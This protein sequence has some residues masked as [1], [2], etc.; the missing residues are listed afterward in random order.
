M[1]DSYTPDTPLLIKTDEN[2]YINICPIYELINEGKIEKDVLG[3][4]YDASKKNYKVLCLS[5][6]R[7]PSYI[8]RHKTN[9]DI[10]KISESE[11][12]MEVDVT[13]DHSLFDSELKKVS[14]KDLSESSNLKYYTDNIF[15]DFNTF[16]LNNDSIN[17]FVKYINNGRFDRIHKAVLNADIESK[18]KILLL[19]NMDT[20]KRTKTM[21]AGIQFLQ[22]C[23][24]NS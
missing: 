15:K 1:G 17:F 3:R 14:P 16:K 20:I 22:N 4:E 19:I 18:K 2:D 11:R 10:Y 13:E 6:W 8:Y 21:M 7:Y 9:K 5:G 24:K 23:T 12:N